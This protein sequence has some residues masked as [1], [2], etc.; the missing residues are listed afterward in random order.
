M[1]LFDMEM[2]V[3]C[4]S[5][6]VCHFPESLGMIGLVVVVVRSKDG[7][8]VTKNATKLLSCDCTAKK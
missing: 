2:T 3:R 5:G 6:V 4:S 1:Q 7:C 8:V